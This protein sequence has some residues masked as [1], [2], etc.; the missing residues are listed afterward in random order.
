MLVRMDKREPWGATGSEG[1]LVFR[2]PLVHLV[3]PLFFC[4]GGKL[5]SP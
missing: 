5:R 3:G 4:P 2:L 1:I